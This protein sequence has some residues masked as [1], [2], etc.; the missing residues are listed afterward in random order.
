MDFLDLLKKDKSKVLEVAKNKEGFLD[1][2]ESKMYKAVSNTF[3]INYKKAFY[4]LEKNKKITLR[5][6]YKINNDRNIFFQIVLLDGKNIRIYKN[7]DETK[8][9]YRIKEISYKSFVEF[10]KTKRFCFKD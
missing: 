4:D 2:L 1:I 5:Y 10:L 6:I 7:L 8:N 9:A 3:K